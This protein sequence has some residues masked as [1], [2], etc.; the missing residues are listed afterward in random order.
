MLQRMKIDAA[1]LSAG[2]AAYDPLSLGI[3]PGD[4]V[5]VDFTGFGG[6][7]V[8]LAAIGSRLLGQPIDELPENHLIGLEKIRF[9]QDR[10]SP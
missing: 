8:A 9:E 4:A 7:A 6:D 5:I 10:M 2:F 1:G 3:E